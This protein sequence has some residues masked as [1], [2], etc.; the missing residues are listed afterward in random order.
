MSS[1][2]EA[3]EELRQGKIIIVIDDP[4]RENEGDLVMAAEFVTDE[5]MAFFIRYTGGIICAPIKKSLMEKLNIEM[6]VENNTDYKNT[7][8]TESIDYSIGTTTGISAEDRVKTVRALTYHSVQPK[9][10]TRPGHVFPLV[11][12]EGG[13][14]ARGGHTEAGVDLMELAGLKPVAIISELMNDDGTLMRNQALMEFARKW[15][16]PLISVADII[17]YKK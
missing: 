17:N 9:D 15:K 10:F 1:L 16:M 11:Y 7:A 14:L 5:Q 2:E 4:T 13:V 8:F 6:M 12:A 3:L